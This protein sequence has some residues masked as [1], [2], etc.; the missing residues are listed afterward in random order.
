MDQDVNPL[1]DF[2]LRTKRRGEVL[3]QVRPRVPQLGE[4]LHELHAQ[5]V[6]ALGGS[7]DARWHKVPLTPNTNWGEGLSEPERKAVISTAHAL[8]TAVR[9]HLLALAILAAGDAPNRSLFSAARA[10]MEASCQTVYLLGDDKDD[11]ARVIFAVNLAIESLVE[12]SKD[13]GNGGPDMTQRDEVL[14]RAADIRRS[15]SELGYQLTKGGAQL[16]PGLAPDAIHRTAGEDGPFVYRML[17][18]VTHSKERGWIKTYV[19]AEVMA[20][21]GPSKRIMLRYWA[22]VLGVCFAAIAACQDFYGVLGEP[23][24]PRTVDEVVGLVF[25][26]SGERDDELWADLIG[27]HPEL[28]RIWDPN[29]PPRLPGTHE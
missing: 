12:E 8:T 19:G 21:G 18:S 17:S 3:D 20:E 16:K 22:S 1:V 10:L 29:D 11:R 2:M 13:W 25:L 5:F 23:V 4:R 27:E 26:A 14:E 6:A 28:A 24:T 9:D 15:F 7:P